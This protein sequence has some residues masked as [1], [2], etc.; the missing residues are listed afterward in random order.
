MHHRRPRRLFNV[1]TS[2]IESPAGGVEKL[3]GSVSPSLYGIT[4]L[5]A[6]IYYKQNARDLF[7]V[8]VLVR[9]QPLLR[10]SP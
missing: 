4:I 10:P 1:R 5:Q 3:T 7:R 8:K 9:A 6:F 2:V